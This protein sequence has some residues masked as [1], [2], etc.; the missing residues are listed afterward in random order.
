MPARDLYHDCVKLALIA[1][2]WTIAHAPLPLKIGRKDLFV[3]LGAEKLL[4][5]DKDGRKIAV[6]VKSFLGESE[7]EDLEK[8]LNQFIRYH[9]ILGRTEPERSSYLAIHEDVFE[10][11]FSPSPSASCCWK[12]TD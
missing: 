3:D 4:A 11:I 6:E 8:A 9:D 12:A 2:G 7:V 1:D 5:A 10:K